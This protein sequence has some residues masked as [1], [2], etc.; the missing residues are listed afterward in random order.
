M[1]KKM[2]INAEG[3]KVVKGAI[4]ERKNDF[5]DVA[6]EWGKKI[7]KT[8]DA[9]GKKV[10]SATRRLSRAL[11]RWLVFGIILILVNHFVPQFEDEYPVL[12]QFGTGGLRIAEFIY[13]AVFG[14][15][16]SL[17]NGTF[18]EFWAEYTT[19]FWN[20]IHQIGDWMMNIRF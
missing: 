3:M 16:A 7:E 11:T 14:F 2:R 20:G 9:L 17:L 6:P 5:L 8:L 13:K 12:Y 10:D 1:L 15:C 19:S 18:S 4:V